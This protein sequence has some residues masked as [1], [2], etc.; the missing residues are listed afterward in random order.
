V[1]PQR[2]RRRGTRI[3][4][5]QTADSS[6]EP[7][8]KGACVRAHQH[9]VRSIWTRIAPTSKPARF[10][11]V[12]I[13]LLRIAWITLPLT[14]GSLAVE[15]LQPWSSGTRATAE[16]LLWATWL[17]VLVALLAPRP[18]G[19]TAARTGAPL[20]L[21]ATLI[22]VASGRAPALSSIAAPVATTL[23]VVLIATPSFAR[24]CAQGA[25]YGDEERFPLKV[26][27]AL[28]IGVLPLAVLAVGAGIA[29]GPLLIADGD[30]G[31]GSVVLLLGW[32]LAAALLRSLHSLSRRWAILVPA[33]FVIADPMTLTDPVLF[34]REHILGLGPAD[35][36]VRPP[37]DATDLRLGAAHG[38][39]A[40]LMDSDAEIYRRTRRGGRGVP[41]HLLLIAPVAA[42]E[43]L[44]H[45]AARRIRVHSASS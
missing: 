27:P 14:A 16:V 40:L 29:A 33:G 39:L 15:A 9:E 3:E 23:C 32:A 43:L 6:R 18:I 20:L 28:F 2:E 13:L 30:V 24:S 38:S 41:A 44:E 5:R 22:A 17:V 25:A 26:P 10:V 37:E 12:N 31:I 34:V 21:A 19:L 35:P 1:H 7:G 36:R 11:D 45:A 42:A 4:V 8:G